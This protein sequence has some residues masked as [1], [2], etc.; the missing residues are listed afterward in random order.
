MRTVR[1]MAPGTRRRGF[2]IPI[3]HTRSGQ[4]HL[5]AYIQTLRP[6]VEDIAAT[7]EVDRAALREERDPDRVGAA[8]LAA[9]LDDLVRR[10]LD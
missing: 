5:Q 4:K 6:M 8:Y 2:V 9:F 10:L 1:L 3:P 7:L